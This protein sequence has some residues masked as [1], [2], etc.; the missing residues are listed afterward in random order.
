MVKNLPQRLK[1]QDLI[2]FLEEFGFAEAC[3]FLYVPT[4]RNKLG[5]YPRYAFVGFDRAEDTIGFAKAITGHRFR[6]SQKTVQCLPADIQG[7]EANMQHFSGTR[8][9]GTRWC[10]LSPAARE[11]NNASGALN[12]A[13]NHQA[14]GRLKIP[15]L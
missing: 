13:K 2:S 5:V 12:A 7:L 8:V 1:R 6:Q 14:W 15:Q 4:R 11:V 3:N 9:V 10:P